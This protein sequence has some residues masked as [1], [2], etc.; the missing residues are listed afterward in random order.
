[1]RCSITEVT[2]NDEKRAIELS[3]TFA[4]PVVEMF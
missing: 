3:R 1:V 2:I 4:F